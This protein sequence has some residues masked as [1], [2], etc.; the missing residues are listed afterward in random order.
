VPSEV[1]EYTG[2]VRVLLTKPTSDQVM[3]DSRLRSLPQGREVE[4]AEVPETLSSTLGDI[5]NWASEEGCS[6][7]VFV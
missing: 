1:R 5:R 6:S 3:P 7:R 2:C 4:I